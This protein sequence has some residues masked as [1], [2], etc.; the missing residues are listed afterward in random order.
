[1]AGRPDGGQKTQWPEDQITR[2]SDDQ[3]A[4]WSAVQI[5]RMSEVWMINY[6]PNVLP[7]NQRG[8]ALLMIQAYLQ[9]DNIKSILNA[10]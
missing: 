2:W 3:M 10:K 6:T 7:C 9:I 8:S 1:M 5:V 4:G